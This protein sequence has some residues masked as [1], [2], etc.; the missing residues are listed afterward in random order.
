MFKRLVVI[1]GIKDGARRG[2]DE[3]TWAAAM[4]GG[5]DIALAVRG[6]GKTALIVAVVVA[7]D[8]FSGGDG[9]ERAACPAKR[10]SFG[11]GDVVGGEV[12]VGVDIEGDVLLV[13]VGPR[14]W[15][16]GGGGCGS[17]DGNC[18]GSGCRALR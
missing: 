4:L 17:F 18:G 5:I 12:A 3:A 11:L 10:T 1:R 9:L 2:V 6:R 16:Y 13:G 15:E 14:F 8:G 7:A